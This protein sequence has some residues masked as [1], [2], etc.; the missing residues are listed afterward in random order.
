MVLYTYE[1]LEVI[2]LEINKRNLTF[3]PSENKELE[4]IIEKNST[5]LR[6][7]QKKIFMYS[8]ES[9]NHIYY[10]KDG[11]T[12]HYMADPNGTEKSYMYLLKDG[13]LEK[14]HLYLTMRKPAYT[15]RLKLIVLYT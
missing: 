12:R 2:P 13:F 4:D 5:V 11:R 10:I 14:L 7:P 15:Q 9:L 1:G 3:S 6:I 8:G